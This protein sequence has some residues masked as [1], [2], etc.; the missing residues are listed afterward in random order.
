MK[1]ILCI[2]L[3]MTGIHGSYAQSKPGLDS[4]IQQFRFAAKQGLIDVYYPR[5]TDTLYGG[6]ITG[7]SFD[8]KPVGAQDKM[9]V[10]QSR[11]VWTTAE[12]AIFY[13]D[14]SYI[15]LSRHGFYFLRDKM[16]D[17][18][19]GGFYTL[20]TRDGTP[21]TLVKEAYGNAFAIY[22]LATYYKAS[23]DREALKLAQA[24]FQWLEKHSHDPKYKGY[25]QHL[26]KQGVPIERTAD[27]PPLAETGLKDQNS[28]IHLLEAF[29]A[30]Y[31]VW[32]DA[33]LKTRLQEVLTLIRDKIVTDNGYLQLFWTTDWRPV[34]FRDYSEELIMK[35]KNLDHVSFGH[36]V[37]TAYLMEEAATV[38]GKHNDPLT[39]AV[40]KKM[41]DHA[42]KV[43]WDQQLGGFYDEGYYFKDKEGCTIINK[44]KNWWAQAEG[45]NT[46]LIMAE[47][48]PN[49]P[50]QYYQRFLKLWEYVQTYL[51]DHEHGDWYEEGLDNEPFRK[52]ALKAHIWKCTYHNFR[53]L[54][55]C[56]QRLEKLK[57]EG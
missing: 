13:K 20:V 3:A 57:Q 1:H 24:T 23:K 48:Y 25:F 26:S 7:Y 5:N 51:I 15:K 31:E 52:T 44:S 49:D 9:I 39:L 38:I 33:L 37:E 34:S 46:L 30:L 16:W 53:A 35:S 14:T 4:L 54:S 47:R 28:S 12:A 19:D 21:K 42:L 27:T 41:V 43:G 18:K 36:D 11:N 29:T 22:A 6:Y 2:I 45:L 40:G 8:F 55:N 50:M 17:K 32:P 10:T 56:I